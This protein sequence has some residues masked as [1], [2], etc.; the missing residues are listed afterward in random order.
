MQPGAAAAIHLLKDMGTTS[1][2]LHIILLIWLL[3]NQ[4][5]LPHSIITV[6]QQMQQGRDVHF[7][8]QALCMLPCLTSP[9]IHPTALH[10]WLSRTPITTALPDSSRHLRKGTLWLQHPCLQHHITAPPTP[11]ACRHLASMQH[12]T[13]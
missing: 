11:T 12:G 9:Y 6:W 13:A 3:N 7:M 2:T 10:S 8:F 4:H 1:T 5:P